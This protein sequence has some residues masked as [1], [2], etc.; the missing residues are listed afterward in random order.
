MRDG[1]RA[2]AV[3]LLLELGITL[4]ALPSTLPKRTISKRVWLPA[5]S[6]WQTISASR[7][8]APMTFVGF[9]ALSVEMNTN[10][11]TP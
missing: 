5:C 8:V 2:A 6:D 7:F 3:D 4:P 9:T 1:D 11:F 10:F